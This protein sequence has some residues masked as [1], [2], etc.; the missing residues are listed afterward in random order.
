MPPGSHWS[1]ARCIGS[2]SDAA[3]AAVDA[4]GQ[5]SPVAPGRVR[6][7]AVSGTVHG[8]ASLTALAPPAVSAHLTRDVSSFDLNLGQPRPMTA[9]T[10]DAEGRPV[11]GALITWS[12]LSEN[13]AA[14]ITPDGV[15]T[16]H[17]MG[18]ATITA[19]SGTHIA[20][21]FVSVLGQSDFDLI[22]DD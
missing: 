4:I 20:Q 13:G 21:A 12:I 18:N 1:S 3:I 6:I 8:E 11:S 2:T 5:V 17:L 16:G 15:V 14:S 9:A 22:F 7:A 10:L 19:R